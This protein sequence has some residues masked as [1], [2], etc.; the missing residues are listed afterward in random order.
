MTFLSVSGF[1]PLGLSLAIYDLQWP[2]E[3]KRQQG[4]KSEQSLCAY[5]ILHYIVSANSNFLSPYMCTLLLAVPFSGGVP[6][7]LINPCS[8]YTNPFR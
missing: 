1:L 3:E 7:G 5:C 2:T 4:N 8:R 6:L